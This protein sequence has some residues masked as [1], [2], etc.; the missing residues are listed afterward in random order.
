MP[1]YFYFWTPLSIEHL[2]EHGVTPEEFE[3]VVESARR[4]IISDSSGNLAVKGMTES[5]RLLF[6]V[7]RTIDVIEVE[8]ITA[9]EIGP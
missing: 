6:C 4:N 2:A 3:E 5:G 8:A 7:F 9:Y 1:R